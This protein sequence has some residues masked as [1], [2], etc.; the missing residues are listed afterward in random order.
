M[1][2]L[3][4]CLLVVL[5]SASWVS[6]AADPAPLCE[7]WSEPYEGEDAT[8]NRTIALWQFDT[9][10]ETADASGNGHSLTLHNA[11]IA[12]EGRFGGALESFPG[13]PVE[14]KR[15]A[16]VAKNAPSLS[17][18]G[19][20]TLELWIRPKPELN[21]DYPDSFLLDKKYVSHDDY[22][23]ILGPADRAGSRVLRAVLGFGSDSATWYS[24]PARFEPGTWT[25]VAFTYDAAGTGRFFLNGMSWGGGEQPSRKA[26]SAGRHDLSIGDRIG[27]YY[28]GFPGYIDQVRIARGVREF[29][30]LR[31]EVVSDRRVFVR[32]EPNASLLLAITNLQKVTVPQAQITF[33][34]DGETSRT[35]Q[36]GPL[37]PGQRQ[38]VPYQPDTMLRPDTYRLTARV[39][40]REPIEYAAEES[41]P[42][43]IVAR[44]NPDEFPV[45]MWGIYGGV[46]DEIPRLKQ[47]GFTHVLGVGA[48]TQRIWAAE[49]PVQAADDEAVR[50]TRQALDAALANGLTLVASLSPGAGMRNVEEFRRV[51][52]DGQAFTPREDLCGLFPQMAPFC[53]RVGASVAGTYGD[54]P[55][56]GAALLHTEVRDHARP[57]FHPHDLDAFRKATGLEIPAEVSTSRGVDFT[58]LSDF[59]ASRVIPDDHPLYAYYRWYWKTGDGWNELNTALAKGLRSTGRDDLWTFHDPAVRVASVY[60]SGGEVDVLSQWTY[61]Y[62]DPLRIGLATDELLAMADGADR[63]QQVMKMT[64]VIWYRSQTAPEPKKPADR[65]A[66]QADWERE[67]PDA[68]FITIAPIHLR[69]A[70]WTKIARPIRG[71]MYHGWQSL[72]PTDSPGGYRYTHPQT[73]HELSRLVREVVQPLG[74]TLLHV[75]GVASDVAMYESFASEMFARRGT[76]GWGGGWAGDCY[77]ILQYAHLQPE[78][79]FDETILGSGLDGKRVLVM[80]DC[81]VLT[82]SVVQRIQA[83]Q[84]AGGIIV[85]DER[86]CPAI[87]PDIAI[88]VYQRTGRADRDKGEL[89]QR[90]AALREALDSRYQRTV[91]SSHPEV[92]PYRRRWG[93]ADYVFAVNDRREYGQYVGHHGIVMENGL[94]AEAVLSVSRPAGAV[95]DLVASRRVESQAD[96]GTV[97]F[98]VRL[99]P[100]D[101]C[102]YLIA[103]RPIAAVGIAV[104]EAAARGESQEV[105]VTVLDELSKP[106]DAVIPLQVTIRDPEGRLAERSGFYAAPG[107][108]LEI[109]LDIA[110]N[111]RFGIWTID[112]RELAGGHAATASFRVAGP[113]VWPP[114]SQDHDAEIANPEQPKG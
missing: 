30:P 97:R 29:R 112:V 111:D 77:H 23:L 76:F 10:A 5:G 88:P 94:P 86:T 66:Y 56:F 84:A 20:F 102:A 99:A 95:Y 83:F 74:P 71:I 41:F 92:I 51:G 62:P 100:G 34:L 113:T 50:R 44:K 101:G 9:D 103:D 12:A 93:E 15:H 26:I 96:D 49:S 81:D 16:A 31:L 46:T 72:V 109:P 45:L 33:S 25:H 60:G 52:R 35:V 61:S 63:P 91:D 7:R 53:Y 42:L 47:I 22:Q 82:A 48:D 106:V 87:Q 54:H 57:C 59:P 43:Q 24:R 27:S 104:S 70:F 37:D 8:G 78:I 28:H 39:E 75:P 36:A 6:G 98:P 13:W 68:P 14:D 105:A 90:A 55:A 67:Q 107:G 40:A 69:E 17:P 80:P 64:Q 85:G 4:S 18:T 73:Q 38:T 2:R 108:R 11:V 3:A 89:L 58:R 19:A 21:G 32:G 65:P 1:I 79:V 110:A 114:G